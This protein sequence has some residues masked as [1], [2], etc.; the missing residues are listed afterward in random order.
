M[1][2]RKTH[3]EFTKELFL[4]FPNIEIKSGQ[5]VNNKT[6]LS[7]ICKKDGCEWD[8]TPSQILKGYGCPTCDGRR[9]QYTQNTLQEKINLIHDNKIKL[10]GNFITVDHKIKCYCKKCGHYW[11]PR[12][13]DLLKGH[14]CPNCAG[15]KKYTLS[16]FKER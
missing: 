1:P 15:N 4:L 10:I 5:Y 16:L 13:H 7:F 9:V 11:N 8:D 14:G 3:E 2:R 6:K 12:P